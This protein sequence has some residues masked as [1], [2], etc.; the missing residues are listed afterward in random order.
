MI[1]GY[2][3]PLHRSITQVIMLGGVP[4]EIA[5]LNGTL[6]AAL[7]FGMHSLFGLPVGLIIHVLSVYLAKRDPQFFE[8]FRRHIKQ[9]RYYGA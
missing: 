2:E 8:V 6:T 7:V 3:I 9:K 5:I 1:E 4:R